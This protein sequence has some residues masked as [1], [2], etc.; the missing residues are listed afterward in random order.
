MSV[1]VGMLPERLM[2]T[3]EWEDLSPDDRSYVIDQWAIQNKA[4]SPNVTRDEM[5]EF[6]AIVDEFRSAS[7]PSVGEKIGGFLGGVAESIPQSLV[8]AG[9][10]LP[11]YSAEAG[12]NI[13]NAFS[14]QSGGV[15]LQDAPLTLRTGLEV[16]A[17][18]Q[19]IVNWTK[20]KLP[21]E[22]AAAFE[23]MNSKIEALRQKLLDGDEDDS[24]DVKSLAAQVAVAAAGYHGDDPTGYLYAGSPDGLNDPDNFAALV[25]EERK[26]RLA[27]R[28]GVQD[29][30]L[31]GMRT[32]HAD[33]ENLALAAAFRETR[34]PAYFDEMVKRLTMS[35]AELRKASVLYA[36]QLPDEEEYERAWGDNSILRYARRAIY[37]QSDSPIDTALA[38]SGVG[39]L[40]RGAKAAVAGPM[41]LSRLGRGALKSTAVE[42]ASGAASAIGAD[43]LVSDAEIAEQAA[44][45]VLGE[46]GGAAGVFLAGRGLAR[47]GGSPPPATEAAPPSLETPTPAAPPF[48]SEADPGTAAAGIDLPTG[49]AEID[50]SL[51]PDMGSR[52]MP[53]GTGPD[54]LAPPP[55]EAL[56]GDQA[57][58]APELTEA[59]ATD[60]LGTIPESPETLAEQ[61]QRVSEGAKP[62]MLFPGAVAR[63]VA[64]EYQ[65]RDGEGLLIT[66]TSAGAV[67][68]S[69][70]IAQEAVVVAAET[71]NLGHV[72]GYGIGS[73]PAAPTGAMVVRNAQGTEVE[74]VL[75]DDATAPEVEQVLRSRMQEGDSVSLEA[76]QAVVEQRI[77]N[78]Q[79]QA[80]TAPPVVEP[81][82]P[83]AGPGAANLDEYAENRFGRRVKVDQRLRQSWRDKMEPRRY[84]RFTEAE[85]QA[86]ANAWIA[87]QGET[88]AVALFLDDTSGLATPE[89]TVLGMQ[90]ALRLDRLAAATA[91]PEVQQAVEGSMDEVLDQ[92][93]TLASAA[94]Q[95]LRVFGMWNKMSPEG[96]LRQAIRSIEKARDRRGAK[97]KPADPAQPQSEPKPG[98]QP[99]KPGPKAKPGDKSQTDNQS[100]EPADHGGMPP[101]TTEQR[102]RL[103]AIAKKIWSAP[104][105][106]MKQD[107][108][109]QL[110][111]E[112]ARI[113]G[114]S[115][116][117]VATAFWY[118]NVLSGPDTHVVNTFG[119]GAHLL[120]RMLTSFMVNHPKDSMAMV[121]GLVEG[122]MIGL[123]DA[124]A[125]LRG[126]SMTSQRE[127]KFSAD[128]RYDQRKVLELLY[129]ENPRTWRQKAGNAVALGRY[130]GRLLM[131]E[132]GFWNGTARSAAQWMAASRLARE[133]VREGKGDYATRMAAELAN[134]PDEAK[135]A[136]AQAEAELRDAG[137]PPRPG[138]VRRRAWEIMEAKRPI[139]VR[140]EGRRFAEV[141]TFN[142]KPEGAWGLVAEGLQ[143][144]TR[145]FV[146]PT[147]HGDLPIFRLYVF[148]FVN[149]VANVSSMGLD[150]TP[151]G[152]AR[153][154]KG[155]HLIGRSEKLTPFSEAERRQ[156]L[157]AG[158][159]G[160]LAMGS[161]IAAALSNDEEGDPWFDLI[162]SGPTDASRRRQL[163]A[164]GWKPWS[165]KFGDTYIS[166]Q[167]FPGAPA[168][169][170]SAAIVQDLRKAAKGEPTDIAGTALIA[171]LAVGS[172]V[173]DRSFLSGSATIL[174]A[175][176]ERNAK[177]LR[178]T[179]IRPVQGFIPASSLLRS[180]SRVTDP[181]Q[182]ERDGFMAHFLSGLPV[183]QSIGTRPA[184]NAFGEPVTRDWLQR[185][186]GVSRF[187]SK[188]NTDPEFSW[189]AQHR[190]WISDV[191]DSAT[192]SLPNAT[193]SERRSI[194]ALRQARANR[195]GRAYAETMHPDE[196]YR[197]AREAGPLTRQAVRMLR[198]EAAQN[199]HWTQEDLQ[200]RLSARVTAARKIAKL[201]MLDSLD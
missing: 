138:D 160:T 109:R 130:V 82:A 195:M 174:K 159:A 135:A 121:R 164:Q 19:N 9:M 24:R 186:P 43:A 149:V 11:M 62:G 51:L 7:A 199:P 133:G 101:I 60:P 165:F 31:S 146:I 201:R 125:A 172:S 198:N 92:L 15:F 188:A 123:D 8:A 69:A 86:H 38:L 99:G 67:L 196:A 102:R 48:A 197:Y 55:D 158:V 46:A 52:Q 83:N 175:I 5:R 143:Y 34:N 107:L 45:E 151:I 81:P 122:V 181:V 184:L 115:A 154:I 95:G 187:G 129:I 1:L 156:R 170:A 89:R 41:T 110:M 179:L 33:P 163:L 26:P 85:L 77:Q 119:S 137:R 140:A 145:N 132:D 148:P 49:S 100:T 42:G 120:A 47:L 124:R 13:G 162:A 93:E 18:K 75:V 185:L 56:V 96:I 30:N 90:L 59:T 50:P 128:S 98:T 80:P 71:G 191:N 118:A 65:P 144:L 74:A 66:D 20:R 112:V 70:E 94:G 84:K 153:G 2:A 139:T 168:F 58:L 117:D 72:L 17:T 53:D 79:E 134:S 88:A 178:G 200:T 147:R 4:A 21:G 113:N 40:F 194:E 177:I 87:E 10:S 35:D 141:A 36:N 142:T 116:V 166:F 127:D 27:N 6:N 180:I 157:A 64:A 76:P 37:G 126:Q 192:I 161:L 54:M 73:K 12:R 108:T 103:E 189:L 167:E 3:P 44:A 136:L 29:A 28:Y 63:D 22:K 183:I 39:G 173:L 97:P 68:H 176:Q 131:A 25:K 78:A 106:I 111:A 61:R 171:G 32:I 193:K 190:L 152:I 104:E 14:G 182:P 155:S 16:P 105:G 150:F 57:M 23:R 91:D 114:L 169:A